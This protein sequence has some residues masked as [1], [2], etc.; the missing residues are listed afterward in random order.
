[1][2]I[3]SE[4]EAAKRE[5][6]LAHSKSWKT[7]KIAIDAV[8]Q[9]L[10]GFFQKHTA[11]IL[12]R[13]DALE[14]ELAAIRAAPPPTLADNYKGTWQPGETYARGSLATHQGGLWLAKSDTDVR[15]GDGASGWALIVKRGRDASDRH[16]RRPGDPA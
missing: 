6:Q 12:A 16:N 11:P 9:V 8:A 1:M 14:T 2:K 15:P 3:T 4:A 10:P 5:A 13:L 7:V